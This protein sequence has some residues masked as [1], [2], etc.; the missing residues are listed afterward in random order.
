MFRVLILAYGNPL[1]SDD[2]IAWRAADALEAKLP[3]YEVEILRLHQLGPELAEIASRSEFIIFLDAASVP[4]SLPGEIRVEEIGS[5]RTDPRE[6]S[7]F[8]HVLS[9]QTVITL[10][11]TLYGAHPKAIL[12]TVTG[13]N[14]DHGESLSPSVEAA[15]P[16]LIDRIEGVVQKHS[17]K[18]A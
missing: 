4:S 13:A 12:I 9:P 8:S 18:K 17:G 14:F 15:L 5:E 1:R 6:A 3:K 10:A 16:V 2:G 11:D 7:P